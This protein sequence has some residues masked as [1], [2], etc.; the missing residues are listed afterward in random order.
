ML[1]DDGAPFAD[2]TAP[3]LLADPGDLGASSPAADRAERSDTAEAG[4]PGRIAQPSDT[5]E[6]GGGR[7]AELLATLENLARVPLAEHAEH[8]EQIHAQLQSRLAEID[9][10]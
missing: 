8:Y 5:A 10:A 3:D 4:P 1:F 6:A 2:P 7:D 9:S